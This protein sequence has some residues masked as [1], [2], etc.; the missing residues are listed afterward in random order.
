[1][2]EII[3]G[4]RGVR[5]AGACALAL[6]LAAGCDVT[7]PGPV[8]DEFVAEGPSQQGLINGAKRNIAELVG[9]GAYTNGILAREIFPGGQ[10]GAWGHDVIV[11][12]GHVLPGSLGGYFN[13]AVQARFIS[14][15]AIKRFA[16][17]DAPANLM[18]Q[19]HLW[20]GYSYR[21][22]GEWW[23]DAVVAS[24]DPDDPEPGSFEAGTTTYFERAVDNFTAALQYAATDDERYAALAGRAAAHLWLG[25][26]QSAGA[27]AALVPDGFEFDIEMFS[28]EDDYYN[29]LYEAV[30]GQF[31][32]YSVKF[33][34]FEDYYTET[35]DPRTPWATDP[36][37][38]VAVGSLQGF[39]QVP[40]QRQLKYTSRNDPIALASG[41]EMRLVEA[42]AAL[43]AGDWQRAMSLVNQVRTRNRSDKTG[44]PLE[45]WVATNLEE[46]WTHLKRERA[47]E[48]WLE[49]RRLGDE[50]R[51]AAAG[52]PG[53]LDLPDW[54]G[55]SPIFSEYPRSFCFDIPDSERDANPNVPATTS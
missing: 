18:Y 17:Q 26:W 33:T 29:H 31:R 4:R 40:F 2:R 48:L 1:M 34:W 19:A 13:D 11:Q 36:N 16:A 7:N 55:I 51:W 20:A 23:C 52:T 43:V 50:R 30:S 42:E 9:N 14:E 10:T 46:A 47:I 35:G 41:M 24:T 21:L 44:Q 25:D 27:D 39:G 53:S 8:E 54:S 32:S 22:L 45:P 28:I 49:G 5:A 37:F 38:P 6:L 15:T 12:G 3:I